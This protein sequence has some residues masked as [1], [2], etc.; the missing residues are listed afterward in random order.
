MAI[1]PTKQV[2][3]QEGEEEERNGTREQ[4]ESDTQK[5][6]HR[7]LANPDDIITDADIESVRIGM[8]PPDGESQDEMADRFEAELNV[9]TPRT[10][11]QETK[12]PGEGSENI[13]PTP[14][15]V[16]NDE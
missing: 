15:E 1:D 3:K 12:E 13:P 5:I 16:L 8:T 2:Q 10:G 4:F 11:E 14:W 7:H 9:N 6:I